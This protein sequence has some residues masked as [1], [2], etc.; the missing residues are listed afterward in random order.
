MMDLLGNL[1]KD[2]ICIDNLFKMFRLAW[3]PNEDKKIISENSSL[4]LNLLK[5]YDNKVFYIWMFK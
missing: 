1:F 3:D 4:V 5:S 2:F